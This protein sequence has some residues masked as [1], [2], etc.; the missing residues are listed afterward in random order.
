MASFIQ[1]LPLPTQTSYT[2]INLW[3][4][5]D[6]WLMA[7]LSECQSCRNLGSYHPENSTT[8]TLTTGYEIEEERPSYGTLSSKS[9][10]GLLSNV[11]SL[12]YIPR[13]NKSTCQRRPVT[14]LT[15]CSVCSAS[16]GWAEREGG[17]E[18]VME[19]YLLAYLWVTFDYDTHCFI[20]N[21]L[22]KSCRSQVS[23]TWP[24]TYLEFRK[25]SLKADFR[26]SHAW[27]FSLL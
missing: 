19:L 14:S 6:Q 22:L 12:N 8:Y 3:R 5:F 24:A 7:V 9:F 15:S 18:D 17:R 16:S 4:L 10:L 1:L 23:T 11:C 26:L 25:S 27:N 13:C 20:Q 2:Y 21:P